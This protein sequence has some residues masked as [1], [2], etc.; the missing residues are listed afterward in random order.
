MQLAEVT[1]PKIL[2]DAIEIA[3]TDDGREVME[4]FGTAVLADI[5]MLKGEIR[6]M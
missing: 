1:F 2:K 3:T 4:A 6:S 5:E